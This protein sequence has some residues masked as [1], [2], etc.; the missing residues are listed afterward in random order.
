[1]VGIKIGSAPIICSVSIEQ[2][3]RE[4]AMCA[5]TSRMCAQAP[6]SPATE[7]YIGRPLVANVGGRA[8]GHRGDPLQGPQI[9]A[10]ADEVAR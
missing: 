8:P 1:M 9:T 10:P 2:L 6:G 5:R 3:R 4:L 7:S